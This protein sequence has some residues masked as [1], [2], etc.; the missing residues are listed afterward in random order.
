MWLRLRCS[1]KL[2]PKFEP[3]GDQNKWDPHAI[4]TMKLCVAGTRLPSVESGGLHQNS[5][6]L[7][8]L[9]VCLLRCAAI[10][11]LKLLIDVICVCAQ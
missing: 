10:N 3:G 6:A 2:N 4:V 8:E 1:S 11:H 5:A 9:T 7:L